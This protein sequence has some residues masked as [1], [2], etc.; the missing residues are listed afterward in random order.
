MTLF[1]IVF[2]KLYKSYGYVSC[3]PLKGFVYILRQLMVPNLSQEFAVFKSQSCFLRSNDFSL[4]RKYF[5]PEIKICTKS[6]KIRNFDRG[7]SV[8]S[9]LLTKI[10]F[11][12]AHISKPAYSYSYML[13]YF[14]VNQQDR[15]TDWLRCLWQNQ[16]CIISKYWCRKIR[17]MLV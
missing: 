4:R 2:Y 3:N 9:F 16:T 13:S 7:R 15:E 10:K 8:R 12:C 14:C 1:W 11:S 5:K 6:Q 17:F